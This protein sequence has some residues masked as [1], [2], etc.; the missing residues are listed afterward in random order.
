MAQREVFS[1]NLILQVRILLLLKLIMAISGFYNWPDLGFKTIYLHLVL[2]NLGLELDLSQKGPK[3]QTNTKI[4]SILLPSVS[5]LDVGQLSKL[6]P[7]S[8]TST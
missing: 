3:K 1:N 6:R 8:A 2:N 5:Q 4:K 7:H